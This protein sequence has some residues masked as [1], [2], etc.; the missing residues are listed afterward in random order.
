MRQHV[1]H[2]LRYG[3]EPTQEANY[4]MLASVYA[5]L[6][7]WEKKTRVREAMREKG[8]KK[9]PGST[10]IELGDGI[11][12]FVAGDKSHK[13]KAKIYEMVEEMERKMRAL[14]YVSTTNDVL[15]DIEEED[16]EGALNRHSEKLAIAF[17]LLKTR[18]RSMIRMVKNLRV[19][20]DCHSATKLI[21]LIYEREIVVRDR[22]RFHH[23]KD[24]VC[25][26]K[27]FW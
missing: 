25:S 4:V 26:C 16:K 7:D 12:E 22:N 27:D 9:I 21:S 5:K 17:A 2:A 1:E 20:G 13:E 23:F 15:L 24:G 8:I 6:S 18:P 19:C 11:Y 14:G 10:M 3:P